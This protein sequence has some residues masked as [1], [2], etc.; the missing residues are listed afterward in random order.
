LGTIALALVRREIDP[1][2][3]LRASW[4]G[5]AAD[6]EVRSLPFTDRAS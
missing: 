3:V 4:D 5:Q 6:A 1:G 2:A